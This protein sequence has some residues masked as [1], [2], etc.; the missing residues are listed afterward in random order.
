MIRQ[1]FGESF[2]PI[3]G[4]TTFL[5][6]DG[7]L[8]HHNTAAGNWG[9]IFRKNY[10]FAVGNKMDATDLETASIVGCLC[11]PIDLLAD[12]I[13]LPRAEIGDLIVIFQSGAYGRTA[14]P[15]DFLSIPQ[16][17]EVLV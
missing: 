16:P 11:T 3:S 17:E 8:H 13:T 1:H 14:S 12:N 6:T 7:G 5:V 10:P 15:V 4:D 2:Q 9:Q